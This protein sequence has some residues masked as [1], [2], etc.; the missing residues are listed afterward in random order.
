MGAT[1][2]SQRRRG[3]ERVGHRVPL[4]GLSD[5]VLPVAGKA[6]H[7]QHPAVGQQCEGVRVLSGVRK[8]ARRAKA[9]GLVPHLGVRDRT[10][11]SS[12]GG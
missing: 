5:R 12:A 6:T 10:V 9:G 7:D 3:A 1:S 4:L 11:T 8:R 2:L